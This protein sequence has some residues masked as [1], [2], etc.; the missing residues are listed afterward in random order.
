MKETIIVIV[1]DSTVTMMCFEI[2]KKE[3]YIRCKKKKYFKRLGN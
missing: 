1:L 3:Y 2:K